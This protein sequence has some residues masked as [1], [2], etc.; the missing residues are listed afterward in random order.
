MPGR[1]NQYP[2]GAVPRVSSTNLPLAGSSRRDRGRNSLGSLPDS[3]PE[4]PIRDSAG[5][6]LIRREKSWLPVPEEC[7][8]INIYAMQQFILG[9]G[10]T[11]TEALANGIPPENLAR[12]VK[13]ACPVCSANSAMMAAQCL[14]EEVQS[15]EFR[16]PLSRIFPEI[17][18]PEMQQL[19]DRA[20]GGN[21]RLEE[22]WD[23]FTG[24]EEAG[25]AFRRRLI[26]VRI[27]HDGA[28][29]SSSSSDGDV[30]QVEGWRVGEALYSNPTKR[31]PQTA[32][33]QFVY[34][35]HRELWLPN[36]E[37]IRW[38][39]CFV[40]LAVGSF[41]VALILNTG[42]SGVVDY[43]KYSVDHV[44]PPILLFGIAS[45]VTS[46]DVIAESSLTWARESQSGISALAYYFAKDIRL[47]LKKKLKEIFVL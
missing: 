15:G 43:S 29:S 6:K 16:L 30:P 3:I 38:V 14:G 12:M 17:V 10:M 34:L 11:M 4:D 41:S 28:D 35:L 33:K 19:K 32:F 20:A 46:T 23:Q 21:T 9:G 25:K 27:K 44:Q 47:M 42:Q 22:V 40:A 18:T 45:T 13:A 26:Q 7:N 8:G 39:V 37:L 31:R 36:S 1:L 24:E 5:L 2:A